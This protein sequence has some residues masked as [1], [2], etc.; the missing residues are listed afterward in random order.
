[1]K[2]AEKTFQKGFNANAEPLDELK[3]AHQQFNISVSRRMLYDDDGTKEEFRAALE[4]RRNA[5]TSLQPHRNK[6]V[7]SLRTGAAIKNELPGTVNQENVDQN[8]AKSSFAVHTDDAK[9]GV[10]S[11]P[12]AAAA[13]VTT[14]S[15]IKNILNSAKKKENAHEPGPWNKAKLGKKGALFGKVDTSHALRFDIPEDENLAPI[16]YTDKKFDLGIQLP[17]DWVNSNTVKQTPWEIPVV[18]EEPKSARSI[19]TYDKCRLYP[20]AN[21]EISPEEY[22]A[23]LW[24]K[25]LDID[26]TFIKENE[27]YW[28]NCF[29]HGIHLY[30]GFCDKSE[31]QVEKINIPHR[32]DSGDESGFQFKLNQLYPNET[33]VR[34]F[35]ELLV[36]KWHRGDIKIL[37]EQDFDETD[38]ED[39][40]ELTMVGNRRESVYHFASR[41]SI[42]P[43]KS[44]APRKS[45]AAP[46]LDNLTEED[47]DDS[48]QFVPNTLPKKRRSE[49][50]LSPAPVT[51]KEH[52]EPPTPLNEFKA[53]APVE[54]KVV[55]PFQFEIPED[56]GFGANETCSTQQFNFFL[57]AQLASTP[58]G[59]KTASRLHA[60]AES[61]E[62]S[63]S[64]PSPEPKEQP[65]APTT[66][67]AAE[68]RNQLSTIM[69]TSEPTHSSK[70]STVST[71]QTSSYESDA[72]T[73]SPNQ[74]TAIMNEIE[75]RMFIPLMT[76]FK[77]PDDQT[78]TCANIKPVK[79]SQID[80]NRANITEL[81][82][83]QSFKAL[84]VREPELNDIDSSLA[85]PDE[86]KHHSILCVPS[87][88]DASQIPRES[89]IVPP[90]IELDD[91]NTIANI[92]LPATQS[93]EPVVDSQ[94][95]KNSSSEAA[96]SSAKLSF[97]I[98]EDSVMNQTKT[99]ASVKFNVGDEGTQGFLHVSRKENFIQ[100]SETVKRTPSDEFLDL[101]KSPGLGK[102]TTATEPK[103]SVRG[104][105]SDFMK[106]SQPSLEVS[107][108][109]LSMGRGMKS[110]SPTGNLFDD[111]INTERFTLGG[112][113]NSTLL[114]V[115]QPPTT[116]QNKN[117]L[118]LDLSMEMAESERQHLR[119]KNAEPEFKVP[120]LPA[121]IAQQ[122]MKK[123]EAPK[124]NF[125]IY[126][127]EGDTAA[128]S[129]DEEEDL[130]KT[131]YA[132]RQQPVEDDEWEEEKCG[133]A[134]FI[135]TANNR[136]E[137]TIFDENELTES[138]VRDVIVDSN[139]N[140]FDQRIRDRMLEF[141][142]FTDYLE[143][144][145]RTCSLVKTIPKLKVA[146]NVEL[147]EG[148]V[149][150][151]VKLIGKGSY[152]SVYSA[153]STRSGAMFAMKQQ[154][155]ANLWEYYICVE[156]KDRMK[157]KRM[158][159]AFMFIEY[160]II[161][162][163]SSIYASP[164]SPYGT[165]IDVCNKYKAATNRNLDEYVVMVF[166]SQMLNII[167]HLHSCKII[168]ADVKPDNFLLM[169]K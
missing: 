19:P 167:D 57:K 74:N 85:V 123:V 50:G 12:S 128:S 16:S 29:E 80:V 43:R 149:L 97:N 142:S 44:V 99:A 84:D 151:V 103:K 143:K 94:E 17:S 121:S 137:H 133:M 162:N 55:K 79:M 24:C 90:E 164:F 54:K 67:F 72:K 118:D 6:F 161:G 42:V 146:Q 92:S 37:T 148:E 10:V 27:K 122:P 89:F 95:I 45:M 104:D 22:R 4:E 26:A 83:T 101:L 14:G 106:F 5:L 147:T 93:Q 168:H 8:A 41:K 130:S 112:L 132:E 110:A 127:D 116:S 53:P 3:Q 158:L 157:D 61:E 56:E 66:P 138:V 33:E 52:F 9:L 153:K 78:E 15:V 63:V 98:Y 109:G 34:S 115:A 11:A 136:Y 48:I 114:P 1:M 144:N 126:H 75:K 159:P 64:A 125:D 20:Q 134:S 68:I 86:T 81:K 49:E 160:S 76:S 108:Q 32:L 139:G 30:P 156:I 107:M 25:K 152:A 141:C 13:A 77:L 69:E 150:K 96:K 7:G 166:A 131:I 169:R 58:V 165:V 124:A 65:V 38:F 163:N 18:A 119:N 140:P 62:K 100:P 82:L 154:K 46:K 105:M 21:I 60:A 47:E 31:V 87:T 91:D 40:M 35:D 88:Q 70:L 155:P 2:S 73:P 28:K 145:I 111:D 51:K 102:S 39:D 36:D 23:Y 135:E 113:K 120:Q 117:S 59:K 129:T 71:N